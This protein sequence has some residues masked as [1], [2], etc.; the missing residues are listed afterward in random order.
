MTHQGFTEEQHGL[1]PGRSCATQLL[2]T[3][4]EWSATLDQ[5]YAVDCIYLD[6]QKAFDSVPHGRLLSKLST[7]GIRGK[8][9]EWIRKFLSGRKQRVIIN[10]Q[11]SRWSAVTS[12]IY[13]K[14][15]FLD[16]FSL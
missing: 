1:V 10:G 9:L 14:V 15:L 6:F 13:L 2:V 5:G 12:G 11:K 16:L 4:E 7:Y 3:L 8:C